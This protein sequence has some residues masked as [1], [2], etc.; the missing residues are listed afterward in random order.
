MYSEEFIEKLNLL[1]L[2]SNFFQMRKIQFCQTVSKF[3]GIIIRI[4]KKIKLQEQV[5]IFGDILKN[6]MTVYEDKLAMQ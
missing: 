6:F 2:F 4:F 5:Q 3:L 1:N